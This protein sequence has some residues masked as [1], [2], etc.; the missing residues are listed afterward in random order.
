MRSRLPMLNYY[1]ICCLPTESSDF[2]LD[3]TEKMNDNNLSSQQYY[4]RRLGLAQRQIDLAHLGTSYVLD[5]DAILKA[6]G[7]DPVA[8][9]IEYEER[10]QTVLR[11]RVEQLEAFRRDV[12]LHALQESQF[13]D[14]EKPKEVSPNAARVEELLKTK[15]IPD[16]IQ[17]FVG[18][19]HLDDNPPM[20]QEFAYQD[21]ENAEMKILESQFE[22]E[23]QRLAV[24]F[25]RRHA[26]NVSRKAL[27]G[28][29]GANI[30]DPTF[31]RMFQEK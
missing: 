16:V 4:K 7:L 28:F 2:D 17:M 22:M 29:A 18:H 13:A 27:I 14:W 6:R 1:E 30:C 5:R 12:A 9:A 10:R 26:G 8:D 19:Y 24:D 20:F 25:L 11:S 3:I 31:N 23:C 15:S 21:D